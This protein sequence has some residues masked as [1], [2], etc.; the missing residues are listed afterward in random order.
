MEAEELFR[1]YAAGER[2]FSGVN[3]EEVN[4]EKYCDY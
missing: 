1:K 2:D 4:V 3:L